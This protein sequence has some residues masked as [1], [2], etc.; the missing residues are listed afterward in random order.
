MTFAPPVDALN[1]GH[2]T[3][4]GNLGDWRHASEYVEAA[5][6][7]ARRLGEAADLGP[8]QRMVDLGSGA[9]D[10]LRMWVEGF[11]VE[12][13]T[14]VELDPG[15]ARRARERVRAWG[16]DPRVK[17]LT[18]EATTAG[19]TDDVV[20]RVVALD[21][22]YFFE[23]R[24]TLLQRC[25]AALRPEGVLALTDLLLGDGVPARVAVALAPFFGVQK[26][27]LLTAEH[28]RARFAEH[29]FDDVHIHDCTDD[30]LG[31]FARWIQG[32]GHRRGETAT[33]A[34]RIG[35][36]I[37]GRAAGFLAGPTGLRYVVTTARRMGA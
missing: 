29:G 21:S 31:G 3:L 34:A 18:G 19:W 33:L 4:W 8:G 13:V 22:A 7:L 23:S 9:G 24:E 27:E 16:L 6:A 28:Y 5:R 12:H 11:G 36:A 15:L 35:L 14:A 17:V 2:P 20:D 37:T 25:S 32:G 1:H 10:Q 30:V 26:G